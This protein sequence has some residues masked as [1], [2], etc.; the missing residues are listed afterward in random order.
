[1][2][3]ALG[4]GVGAMTLGGMV[5]RPEM[6][7]G[8]GAGAGAGVGTGVGTA[9][10]GTTGLPGMRICAAAPAATTISPVLA[11]RI[12][13]RFITHTP[14]NLNAPVCAISAWRSLPRWVAAVPSD[15]LVFCG[16]SGVVHDRFAMSQTMQAGY[17]HTIADG[18]RFY[19]YGYASLL[20][21]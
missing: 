4:G 14:A 12:E 19:S 17:A 11:N 16:R 10:G 1:L 6:R 7:I 5:G 8:V 13:R 20:L 2:I 21:P 15:D 18:Y 3:I 9:L